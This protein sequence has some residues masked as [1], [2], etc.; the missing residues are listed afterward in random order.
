MADGLDIR[1]G[2]F[3]ILD[4]EA[5][6]EESKY[7][8]WAFV[9]D[10]ADGTAYTGFKFQSFAGIQFLLNQR[11]ALLSSMGEDQVKASED[12]AEQENKD[13]GEDDVH[14]GLVL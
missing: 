6:I 11:L 13:N 3:L 1:E 4:D 12:R 9:A 2:D 5:V 14:T 10:T 7:Q 8:E